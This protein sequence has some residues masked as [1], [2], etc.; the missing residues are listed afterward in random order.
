MVAI[1][2]VLAISGEYSTGMIRITFTAM[3]RRV[4]RAGRQGR[5]R[6]PAWCWPPAPSPCSARV[7]AGQLILPGHGF[8]RPRLPAAV[9]GDG[10]VLRAA[11]GLGAVPG[12]DRACS[13]WASPP[14]AG[15][16]AAIGAVLGLL[17]LFPIIAASRQRPGTGSG[18]SSRSAPMTAGLDIQ[19][20]TA[21]AACRSA[22]GPGSA[23]SPPGPPRRCWPAACCSGS[24]THDGTC[25]LPWAA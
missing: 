8:T 7:L 14:R 10:P 12:P 1:L 2:A 6:S 20:T 22:P 19:A 16:G 21:C 3:P 13:A 5:R 24:A 9:A 11:A 25:R 4:S 18:T 15:L 17:Y 23:C